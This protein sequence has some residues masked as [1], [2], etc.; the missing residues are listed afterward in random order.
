MRWSIDSNGSDVLSMVVL[1]VSV[2]VLY[3]IVI[4]ATALLHHPW[5]VVAAVSLSTVLLIV[6]KLY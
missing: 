3:A 6:T 1:V 2:L 5:V 4:Y